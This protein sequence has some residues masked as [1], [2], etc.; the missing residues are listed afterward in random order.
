MQDFIQR[1]LDSATPS[2][3]KSKQTIRH[4]QFDKKFYEQMLM[5][6]E[7]FMTGHSRLSDKVATGSP[8]WADLWW[9]L[10][11]VKPTRL[12]PGEVDD[13]HLI[14]TIVGEEMEGLK[15]FERL[16]GYVE[17]DDVAC[18][19]ACIDLRETLEQIFD[20]TK[21]F[22]DKLKAMVEQMMV[23]QALSSSPPDDLSVEELQE[24]IEA[25]RAELE[26]LAEEASD[27]L[28]ESKSVIRSSLREG[29]NEVT[30]QIRGLSAQQDLWM[31]SD[32]IRLDADERLKLARRL[33]DARFE[34][35]LKLIGP[36][37]RV[38]EE[39]Q[40]RKTP[41]ANTEIT[42]ISMG[43]DLE[44]VLPSEI[45]LLHHPV[46]RYEFYRKF[47]DRALMQYEYGG[48]EKV[49]RGDIIA[50]ID[51]SGS[52]AGHKEMRAKAIALCSLG[53]ARLQDR[54][55]YGIHFG[56]TIREIAEF[57]FTDHSAY[58]P[59]KVIEFAEYFRGG[60]PLRVD[61]RVATPT[62]W[63][64][65]GQ[66]ATGDEVFGPDGKPTN[67]LGVFPQGEL[68][69][70]RLTFKDGAT[71]ICDG[72]HIWHVHDQNANRFR[73]LTL[74]QILDMGLEYKHN[75]GKWFRFSVPVSQPLMLDEV[76]L[77]VDPY[78]LGY[79]LGDGTLGGGRSVSI[80]S[81]EAESPW[82]ECLPEGIVVTTYCLPS[83]DRCGSYGLKGR[84]TGR[85]SSNP[86]VDGLK[87][88]GLLGVR[89]E[90]KFVPEAYLWASIEQRLALLSGLLDSDGSVKENGGFEFSNCSRQLVDAVVH[91]AQSLGGVATISEH[92]ARPN[93]KP[94]WRV[95]GRIAN[96]LGPPFRLSRKRSR[97][98]QQHLPY[99]RSIVKAEPIGKGDAVCILVDRVDGLFL[100]EGM[101]VTHN[102]DFQI[103][104]TIA[105]G[106][107]QEQER[108]TGLISGDIM[109][110]TDGEAHVS[111][112]WLTDFMAEKE[113]LEFKVHG[114]LIGSPP[115]EPL[116]TICD[117]LYL[118]DEF[119]SS[120]DVKEFFESI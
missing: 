27:A 11:K 107:L 25:A 40:M 102:T 85:H 38:M 23:L 82:R 37:R 2:N 80:H 24:Q 29:M 103:P 56:G 68:D 43:A 60:G 57:D 52:M 66:L 91:L 112:T 120:G 67:V 10:W 39:A 8:M 119:F 113:R 36:M 77:P 4:D 34:E 90:S 86:I 81:A 12:D 42:Q 104:L 41:T 33:Q 13:Q 14:N 72:T 15:E 109:F 26:G 63:V 7:E 50:A 117:K 35:L 70:Y 45:S 21:Q 88:L 44:H 62:G 118:M 20:K 18:A 78:L 65:I 92:K 53:V 31:D 22:Q 79:L 9:M 30:E 69:L 59:E 95:T 28:G 100:T 116:T 32:H 99:R 76:Q 6:M 98:N 58:T 73:E 84:G 1:W 17:N 97:Y 75:Q 93:E 87:E 47:S 48:K 55:F 5:S 105:L 19:I 114:F 106:R 71:V 111:H 74:N 96:D 51:N 16:R 101:V 94:H 3:S 49:G 115:A 54:G 89:S 110:I 61:Q 46:G 108:E 83:K 64:Q